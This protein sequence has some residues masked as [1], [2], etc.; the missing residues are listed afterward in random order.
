MVTTEQTTATLPQYITVSQIASSLNIDPE[1][2]RVY[3]RK[4]ELKAKKIGREFRVHPKELEA[5]LA[6]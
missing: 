2:V 4:G 1:T 6:I 5:F 3:I